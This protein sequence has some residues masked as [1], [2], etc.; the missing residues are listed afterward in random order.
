MTGVSLWAAAT[1][2]TPPTLPMPTA[3]DA[4]TATTKIAGP[5]LQPLK[6]NGDYSLGWLPT[7]ELAGPVGYVIFLGLL[8]LP[9]SRKVLS[10]CWPDHRETVP[11]RS[12]T[13]EPPSA[14]VMPWAVLCAVALLARGRSKTGDR[15][16]S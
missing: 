16:R 4:C 13:Q 6:P 1:S 9:G 2:F 10:G 15:P 12:L 8:L 11:P 7:D 5:R 3:T 14:C